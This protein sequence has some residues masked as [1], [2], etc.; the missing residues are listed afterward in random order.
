MGESISIK[1]WLCHIKQ[2]STTLT[3]NSQPRCLNKSGVL[4]TA[5]SATHF[6]NQ[7]GIYNMSNLQG[8]QSTFCVITGEWVWCC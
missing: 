5:V 4:I 8:V 6:P 2:M 1:F 3:A 7:A